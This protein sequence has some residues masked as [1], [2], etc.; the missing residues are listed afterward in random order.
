[1]AAGFFMRGFVVVGSL[2]SPRQKGY[3]LI[4][5]RRKAFRALVKHTLHTILQA[6]L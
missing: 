3:G 5:Y 6:I 1:M 2:R 4:W